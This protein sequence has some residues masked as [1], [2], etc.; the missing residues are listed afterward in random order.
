MPLD[1]TTYVKSLIPKKV[2]KGVLG[3]DRDRV[4]VTAVPQGCWFYDKEPA[5]VIRGPSACVSWLEPMLLMLNFRIQI[6]SLAREDLLPSHLKV[7]CA[8]E[9]DIIQETLADIDYR[10]R[11]D[12]T[13]AEEEYSESVYQRA[14]GLMAAVKDPDNLFEVGFR[15]TSCLEQHK[16]AVCAI[17]HAGITKTSNAYLAKELGMTAVG[18]MGHEHPQRFFSDYEAFTAMRDRS[19]SPFLFY[20]PD[21]F[22]TKDSGLHAAIKAGLFQNGN[23]KIGIRFDAD[24]M[25]ELYRYAL[26]MFAYYEVYPDIALESGWDLEKTKRFEA[27]REELG[28]EPCR[29]HYGV[30]SYLVNPPWRGPTRDTVQA[31]YKLSC[32]NG[33]PVMK[34]GDDFDS[35]TILKGGGKASI[36]GDLVLNTSSTKRLVSLVGEPIPPNFVPVSQITS[37]HI[38][39]AGSEPLPL[40]LSPGVQ[41]AIKVCCDK[42]YQNLTGSSSQLL[43][44]NI[45]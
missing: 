8:K 24:D 4:S 2:P 6:A 29:Q 11:V 9:R 42:R 13:V 27:L 18:T 45:V 26:N 40:S 36:P 32:T 1:A 15:A 22:D 5:V 10:K 34:F 38:S 43:F 17:L 16:T 35:D 25:E 44:R 20:L 31:V 39:N 21:T 23:V 33:V 37:S 19:S 12:I 28:V 7:T 41:E 30:G 14:L 3:F